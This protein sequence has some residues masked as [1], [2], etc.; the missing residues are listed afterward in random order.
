MWYHLNFCFK[1]A[2]PNG[3]ARQREADEGG[4]GDEG[5]EDGPDGDRGGEEGDH[6][7]GGSDERRDRPPDDGGPA[8]AAGPAQDPL[9]GPSSS[10][11]YHV[12]G[13]PPIISSNPMPTGDMGKG[14]PSMGDWE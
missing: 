11:G 3:A 7:T 6:L 2:R 5:P 8:E 12:P 14:D 13:M 10:P 1:A 9:E 4:S